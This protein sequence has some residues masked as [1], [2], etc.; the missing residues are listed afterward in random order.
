MKNLADRLLELLGHS[1]HDLIF[2]QF[3]GGLADSPIFRYQDEGATIALHMFPQ[4]G[5]SLT[6]SKSQIFEVR[7]D[8]EP[9]TFRDTLMSAFNDSLPFGIGEDYLG[10]DYRCCD[11]QN[12]MGAPNERVT[13]PCGENCMSEAYTM[14][15]LY[16]VFWYSLPSEKLICMRI[17]SQSKTLGQ[18]L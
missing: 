6:S 3:I 16:I 15:S 2:Q 13:N 7:F 17:M 12:L 1:E 5:V 8:I 11:I 10:K 9:T 18:A 14:G 4:L